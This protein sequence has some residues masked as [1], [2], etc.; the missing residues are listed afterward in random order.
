M[1][2]EGASYVSP[3]G[4][5]QPRRRSR[6]S[7]GNVLTD[8]QKAPMGLPPGKPRGTQKKGWPIT[9]DGRQFR[10]DAPRAK[11]IFVFSKQKSLIAHLTDW[12]NPAH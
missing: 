2:N 5:C 4:L 7:L 12:E 6:R 9:S 1:T 11:I 10:H 8:F 3:D